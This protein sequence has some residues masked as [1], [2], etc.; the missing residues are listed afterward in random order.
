MLRDHY[1]RWG[2][3]D[4]N[5]KNSAKENPRSTVAA[6]HKNA[7]WCYQD[8]NGET[9]FNDSTADGSLQLP[10]HIPKD[11]RLL[12][13]ALKSVRDWQLNSIEQGIG[14]NAA[15]SASIWLRAHLKSM[16]WAIHCLEN[17]PSGAQSLLAFTRLREASVILRNNLEAKCT[18]PAVLMSMT[19]FLKFGSS[20]NRSSSVYYYTARRFLLGLAAEALP[21]SHPTLL[22]LRLFLCEQTPETLPAVCRVG[23][24]VIGQ[25]IGTNTQEIWTS[26]I[27]LSHA[28]V[29]SDTNSKQICLDTSNA[30]A[31]KVKGKDFAATSEL[32]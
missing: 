28:A 3:N 12:Q 20:D 4:K 16:R 1:R 15:T 6:M 27:D 8:Q 9:R 14:Q 23:G 31:S 19:T 10:L 17:N 25:C 24:S 26:Q 21:A 5:R 2:I 18:P 30:E 29:M 32:T 22:L 11:S 7:A 13:Q